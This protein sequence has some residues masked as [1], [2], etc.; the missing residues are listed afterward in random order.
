[1]EILTEQNIINRIRSS[2]PFEA[3]VDSGAFTIKINQVVPVV[4]TA[5]HHGHEV[6]E[7]FARKLL[8][9]ERERKIEE[10]PYTGDIIAP[11][12]ITLC[13]HH[14]RYFY[15]LNR[16]PEDCVYDVAWGKKVWRE[17]MSAG[18]TG[19]ITEYH[20]SYY[21]VLEELLMS[22][23]RRFGRCLIY[24]LHSYNYERLEGDPPLFNIGTY[25][26]NLNRYEPELL[27][28]GYRLNEI[29]LPGCRVRTAF[30][31]VFQ[32]RGYQAEYVHARHPESLCVPLEIKKEF[33]DEQEL[34][35]RQPLADLL[36]R[37][38]REALADASAYFTAEK[39]R[40]RLERQTLLNGA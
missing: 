31:E 10:D 8:L 18:E 29:E 24:D 30:D 12:P 9:S 37:N 2:T 14:S 33:M 23:E 1:M 21:R 40:F 4:C 28:L 20:A 22:L 38:M 5:I 17:V 32:G 25:Y 39:T 13:V 6:E 11:F 16:R 27:F 3:R 34:S 7:G 15:D 36:F 26:A 19:Y 35:L